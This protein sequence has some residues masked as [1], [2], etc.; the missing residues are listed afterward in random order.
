VSEG[1]VKKALVVKPS[2]LGDVVHSLPFLHS[3]K[4]CLPALSVDWVI[5]EPLR[6]LLEGHPLIEK[7]WVIKKDD[8]K[9]PARIFETLAEFKAL[10][11]S[12]KAERYDIVFDLQGLLRSGLITK[13]TG[14]PIRIGFREA[15]EGGH[16]FY[17]HKVE[18]GRGI[19]AVDRY[20]KI[21][22]F[23]FGY[24]NLQ[25]E[26]ETEFPLIKLKNF[27]PPVNE[28]AV[29]APG[30]RWRSKRWPSGNFSR[31]ASMLPVKT[32]VI[33]SNSEKAL[34]EEVS[35]GSGGKAI[36]IAGTS[37]LGELVEIL[38]YAKFLITNDSGPMHIGAAL[39]VPVFAV[40]GPTDPALTGP[41]GKGI[42]IVIR[43]KALCAPCR[44]R[45]CPDMRC[46]RAIRL[47][48][49]LAEIQKAIPI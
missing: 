4:K 44:R 38:R 26:T 25:C 10:S 32:I 43:E 1:A 46:M 45:D 15:R 2:S 11:R 40:F 13:A 36:S 23:F 48:R 9:K 27:V 12:L 8:W 14:A 7:L 37:G 20:L 6:G 47:E 17:S 29:L 35:A 22:R 19:H 3:I 21:A 33:G 39:G 5:A 16:L 41:Y 49:V 24:E 18:G 31:L 42:R 30:A 28:Y 34:A